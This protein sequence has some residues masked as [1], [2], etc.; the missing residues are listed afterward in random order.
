MAEPI[1]KKRRQ[2][3]FYYARLCNITEAARRAGFTEDCAYEEGIKTLSMPRYR[4]LVKRL[5]AEPPLSA[6]ALVRAGLERLAFGQANDAAYLVCAE[7]L[8]SPDQLAMLDL[9]NVSELKRVKGGGVEVKF[10]DR[11]RALER[12]YEL[13]SGA[14]S[15][16]AQ[17]EL[18]AA[19]S[20]AD[21]AGK[22]DDGGG[23]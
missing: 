4:Q 8:P 13:A 14:D 5:C 11:Q 6:E 19:I 2:F 22:E 1:H 21:P 18:F 23:A 10:F 7:E 20:G 9:Y 12:L 3:C 17:R 15:A 16:A